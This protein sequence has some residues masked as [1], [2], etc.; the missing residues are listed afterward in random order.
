M[1]S[2]LRVEG[3]DGTVITACERCKKVYSGRTPPEEPPCDTCRVDLMEENQEAAMIYQLCR[4]QVLTF[5][6]G[7][8]TIVTDLNHIAVWEDIDR[9]K[10]KEPVRCFEMVN[11]VF[12]HCLNRER[13]ES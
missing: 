9:Y 10:V 12:H 11:R 3:T 1:Q 4:G 6:N 13:E 5:F 2:Q 8:R 7:E